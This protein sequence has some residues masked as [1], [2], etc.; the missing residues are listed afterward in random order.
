MANYFDRLAGKLSTFLDSRVIFILDCLLSLM[1]SIF[2]LLCLGYMRGTLYAS[3][4]F[5]LLWLTSSLVATIVAMLI[6]KGYKLII[7]HTTLHDLMC[8]V[9]EAAFKF[10]VMFLVM[11]A[12]YRH[13]YAGLM[14]A[15]FADF[16]FT[17][18]LL[19]F[20]RLAM[21]TIY[22]YFLSKRQTKRVCKRVVLFGTG[23]KSIAAVVRLQNST[24]YKVVG[25]L[26]EEAQPSNLLLAN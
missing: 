10:V 7:R 5:A 20:V 3:G 13:F 26:T 17:L 15:L 2:A 22:R 16:L 1:A 12:V 18:F 9:E 6:F 8:F 24:H 23:D 14:F 25:F 21:I 19:V 4:N 11:F